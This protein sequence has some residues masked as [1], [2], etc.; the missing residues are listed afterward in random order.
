M[1]TQSAAAD[2]V[3]CQGCGACCATSSDWPRFSL[4]SEAELAAIPEPLIA[5]DLSGMRCEGDR[6]LALAGRVGAHTACTIYAVRPLV[7]RDCV[8]GDD[9]CTIARVRAGF[10]PIV[11]LTTALTTA[12]TTE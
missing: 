9:A 11:G 12:L 10:A 5:A 6:C 8:P 2:S 3:L 7:C 1:T 4:E